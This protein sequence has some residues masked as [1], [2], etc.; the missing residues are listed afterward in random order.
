MKSVGLLLA[1]CLLYSISFSQKLKAGDYRGVLRREDGI[2]IPFNFQ[3]S[4]E[5]KKPV[6]YVINA[7]EK[8]KVNT[9]RQK[10]DSLFIEM[11]LFEARFY[12]VLKNNGDWQGIFIKGTRTTDQAIP[13]YAYYGQSNRYVAAEG[14]ASI[15]IS[16]RWA[17]HFIDTAT[18]EYAVAVFQ[19][20]GSY[21]TGT[22]LK[23]TGDYRFLQGVVTGNKL[24]LSCFDGSH[25]YAFTAT[26]TDSNTLTDGWYYANAV[27][28][29]SWK[30]V[31]DAHAVLP[32][33]DKPVTLQPGE[34]T[35]NFAFRDINGQRVSLN[36]ERFKH[37]VVVVQLMGSWC[38]NCMD[39]TNFLSAYYKQNKAR[40]VEVVALAYEY[41]TD[42]ARSQK[43]LR[44][45]QERF[46]VTYPML[47]TGVAV[48]DTLRTEKTLPQLT[49]I[50]TFPTTLILDKRGR[51]RKIHNTFYGPGTGD[52]FEKFKVAFNREI[53]ALLAE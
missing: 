18:N 53:E 15:S 36:D 42:F 46:Q 24:L 10:S 19:Q 8:I 6:I 31:R 38:P 25:N 48:G 39:E 49:P 45:F 33:L 29:Q 28:K 17:V 30:A 2:E 51:V 20:S 40:G 47:I 21:V 34:T 3:V 1:G 11:P 12:L 52:A 44:K 37:K 4:F 5:H 13:F 26:V 41:S 32:V 22:F 9:I 50:Q 14:K 43:S 7:S 27:F 16:G 35:L 23:A